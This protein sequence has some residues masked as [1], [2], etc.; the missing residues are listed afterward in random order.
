MSPDDLPLAGLRVVDLADLK[1]ELAGRLLADLGAEVIRV[2]PPQGA[3]SRREPPFDTEGRSLYFAWRNANKLGLALDLDAEAD[4]ERLLALLSRADVLI[5]S[6]RPGRMAERGLDP[7]ALAERFPHL[8]VLSISDFGQYGPYRDW[9]GT[10]STLSTRRASGATSALSPTSS[11]RRSS[12]PKRAWPARRS[13][14]CTRPSWLRSPKP[15]PPPSG[16]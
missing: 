16:R 8:I 4:R 10:D 14:P 2:E 9:L 6:E 5:E 13:C 1:G 3:A 11:T 7:K 15:M 12:K